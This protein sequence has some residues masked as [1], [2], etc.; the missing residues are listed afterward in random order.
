MLPSVREV[1]AVYTVDEAQME[2]VITLPLN[3]PLG[4]PDIQ[5]SRQIGGT[6]HRQ[7]LK[8]LK[9]CILHQVRSLRMFLLGLMCHITF[10]LHFRMVVFGTVC[11]YGIIV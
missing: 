4:V 5:C 8:Q 1:V 3:Y 6:S 2:L 7:W 10:M 11:V 9:M